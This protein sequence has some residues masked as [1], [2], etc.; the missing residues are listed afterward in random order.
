MMGHAD[1]FNRA[2][3][4]TSMAMGRCKQR[5]HSA[6]PWLLPA[7]GVLNAMAVFIA[8]CPVVE[9]EKL[10]KSKHCASLGFPRWFQQQICEALIDYGVFLDKV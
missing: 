6:L 9:M 5:Y 8:L 4:G 2:F 1:H 7:V 3:A 10:K